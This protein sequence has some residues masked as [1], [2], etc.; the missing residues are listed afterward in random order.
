MA[1]KPLRMD[2]RELIIK[3]RS[4]GKPIKQIARLLGISKNTVKV[5]IRQFKSY[6]SIDNGDNKES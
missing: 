3:F 1:Y 2:K 6:D 4:Q 5:Y